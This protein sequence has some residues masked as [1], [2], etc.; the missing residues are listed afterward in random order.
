MIAVLSFAIFLALTLGVFTVAI[1]ATHIYD[2]RNGWKAL[3]SL[4]IFILISY[5]ALR[6][7]L[8]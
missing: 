4:A 2:I 8:G 1:M 7:R 5:G 6:K 3:A